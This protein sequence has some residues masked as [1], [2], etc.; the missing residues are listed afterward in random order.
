MLTEKVGSDNRLSRRA[1][2]V[3][4]LDNDGNPNILI[5]GPDRIHH[6]E[7]KLK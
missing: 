6:F 3:G 1:I 2:A 7:N 4:D 5:A